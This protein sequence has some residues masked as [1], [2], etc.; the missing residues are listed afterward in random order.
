VADQ[1]VALLDEF[2]TALSEGFVPWAFAERLSELRH[3]AERLI[4]P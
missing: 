4:D 3:T 2:E 1:F